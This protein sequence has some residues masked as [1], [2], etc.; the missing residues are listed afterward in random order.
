VKLALLTCILLSTSALWGCAA[1]AAEPDDG[2]LSG[3][4]GKHDSGSDSGKNDSGT[5]QDSGNQGGQCVPSCT[6]DL[7]C[8]NSCPNVPNGIN[9]CDTA[10]GICYANAASS[11]P[12]PVDAGFD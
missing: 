10:T 5:N 7:D 9:C 3:D 1:S 12:V 2:G 8:Q 6:S 11:C 4:S